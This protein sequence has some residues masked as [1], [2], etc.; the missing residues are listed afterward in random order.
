MRF[1]VQYWMRRLLFK[2]YR[3]QCSDVYLCLPAVGEN[4]MPISCELILVLSSCLFPRISTPR[5]LLFWNAQTK[6]LEF[7]RGFLHS[8]CMQ[9]QVVLWIDVFYL[10][11]YR[12]VDTYLEGSPL[13]SHPTDGP[14]RD[15]YNDTGDL[16]VLSLKTLFSLSLLTITETVLLHR[17]GSYTVGLCLCALL[18]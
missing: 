12:T 6:L 13:L 18:K 2:L 10:L 9:F 4:N 1:L 8:F 3:N 11:F 17:E 7:C 15:Q 16:I 5:W 14:P